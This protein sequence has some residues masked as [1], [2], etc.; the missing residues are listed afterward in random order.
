MA[1][2]LVDPKKGSNEFLTA[3][4]ALQARLPSNPLC[5]TGPSKRARAHRPGHGLWDVHA[6]N[7]AHDEFCVPG[8]LGCIFVCPELFDR[9]TLS[10]SEDHRRPNGGVAGVCPHC[11]N[12]LHVRF[13]R[14]ACDYTSIKK[15]INQELTQDVIIGVQCACTNEHWEVG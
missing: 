13:N 2:E 8:G 1:R 11:R 12:N 6:M 3:A 4:S 7:Q 14:W 15:A 9:D 5:I 10:T